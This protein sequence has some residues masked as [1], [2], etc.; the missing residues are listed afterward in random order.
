MSDNCIFC[1]IAQGQIPSNKVY[2]DDDVIAFHDIHPIANVHFLIVP[3][4]HIESLLTL[5]PDDQALL[6]KVLALAPQLAR[7]QGLGEGFRTMINTGAKGGQ[8]VFHLHLH[9]FGGGGKAETMM[10]QLVQ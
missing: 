6:G 3:K 5:V 7:E 2:E 4:R 10:A 1:K 8:S 9:V